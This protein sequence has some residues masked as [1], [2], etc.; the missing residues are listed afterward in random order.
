MATSQGPQSAGSSAPNTNQESQ[1]VELQGIVANGVLGGLPVAEKNQEFFL[2][3][4]GV[5]GTGP[6]II[7]QTAYFIEYLVDSSGNVFKPSENTNALSN[8]LQNFEKNKTV[9]VVVDDPSTDSANMA[10]N[11]TLTAVGLQQ[12]ILYSQTGSSAGAF[13]GSIFFEGDP[14]LGVV[15]S[16]GTLTVP[17]MTAFMNKSTSLPSTQGLITAYDSF[18]GGTPS[19]TSGNARSASLGNGRYILTSSAIGDLQSFT[20]QTTIRVKNTTSSP[21]DLT[22]SIL[23][24]GNSIFGGGSFDIPANSVFQ[25]ITND[26]EVPSSFAVNYLPN[27]EFFQLGL[28]GDI[29][30]LTFD[31]IRFGCVGGASGQNPTS[32]GDL[33]QDS[34][35]NAPPFWLTGSGENLYI[36]ASDF[37]ST[38]YENVQVTSGSINI[39]G[40]TVD[41]GTQFSDF[42]L[43]KIQTPFKVKVGDRIRFLY[44]PS[45]DFHIYDVKEPQ[46]EGD[47]RLKLKLNTVPS[48]S[49][50][51]TQLSNFVL[52]R[53]NESI[54]RY[55]ILN[56]DKTPGVGTSSNPF[57][58]IILPQFPSEKLVSNLDAIL[59]KLKI[60]GIIKN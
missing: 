55:I 53:T 20:V 18:V 19:F 30:D 44:N 5:G 58:G 23:E 28:F 43:S 10:G 4:S 14:S 35:E 27:G 37:L 6:E 22:L 42:N 1:N 13:T 11:H 26:L 47:G 56:V 9:S 39:T 15:S 50:T 60:E 46:N 17:D 41:I 2:V 59:N 32:E 54:P 48:Q 52:H 57:T 25:T 7:G 12:P 34:G 16:D 38:N 3:F 8:L 24:N 51:E 33:L 36:T 21:K 31:Y 40:G 45:T 29:G 49:F